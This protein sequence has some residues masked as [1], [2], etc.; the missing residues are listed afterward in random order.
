[1][2]MKS[3][4]LKPETWFPMIIIPAI[5]IRGGT[6]VRLEQGDFDR[7]TQY[8]APVEMARTWVDGGAT[9]LHIVDLDGAK[10]GA[11]QNLDVVR[12]ITDAVDCAVELGGGM[13]TPS[14]VRAAIQAGVSRVILGTSL[15]NDPRLVSAYL[16]DF[17][18]DELIAG[19]DAR[20]GKVAVHGWQEDSSKDVVELATELH[21]YGI[22]RFIY[23]DIARDG[24]FTGPHLDGLSRLCQALPKATF[25]ASGGVATADHI[26]ELVEL[27]YDNIEGAIVGKAL[28]DGRVTYD[29]LV[30]AI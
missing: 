25:I 6:A 7:E 29:E 4:T 18:D 22:K 2:K 28:Y 11:P 15:A 21:E 23:T 12:A 16:E 27:G 13:R 26:R 19:I 20:N 17:T 5:D 9:L 8:G 3:A 24:M 14:D 1:M 10:E 30:A